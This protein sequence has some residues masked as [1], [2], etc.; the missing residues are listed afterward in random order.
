MDVSELSFYHWSIN[1]V[2][3]P[4]GT[5]T[6]AMSGDGDGGASG[7]E[8]TDILNLFTNF[9]CIISTSEFQKLLSSINQTKLHQ[10]A[11]EDEIIQN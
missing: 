3:R 9:A 10:N 11:V 1:K 5:F 2:L 7:S 4:G 6:Y 8:T